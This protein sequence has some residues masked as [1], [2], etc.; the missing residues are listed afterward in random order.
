[1]K[2]A[3]LGLTVFLYAGNTM[4]F[5]MMDVLSAGVSSVAK[6]GGAAIDQALADSPEEV[7]AKL[8]K[9]RAKRD[10]QFK[11]EVAKIEANQ[12]LSPLEKEKMVRQ[13][14]KTFAGVEAAANMQARSEQAK[15]QQ[16]EQTLSMGG[17]AGVVGGAVMNTP[18]MAMARADMAVK[19]GE[20]KAKSQATLA[21]TDALL[22]TGQVQAHNQNVAAQMNG[23]P[24]TGT[25][26][27]SAAQLGAKV[28]SDAIGPVGTALT[29]QQAQGKSPE[30]IQANY[31]Q[32]RATAVAVKDEA[33]KS[34]N[35][36]LAPV[37]TNML[38]QDKGRK[39]YVEFVNGKKYTEQLNLAFK[40]AGIAMV[41]SAQ[42]AE[43][44][45][46]FDGEFYI[47]P[48]P[49]RK[50]VIAQLGYINDTQQTIE[51]PQKEVSTASKFKNLASGLVVFAVA[52]SGHEVP[53]DP[54][55]GSENTY[56]QKVLIVANR[57]FEGKDTRVSELVEDVQP[58][59]VSGKL[60]GDAMSK[61][62]DDVGGPTIALASASPIVLAQIS[63]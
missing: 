19:S 32:M 22:Q 10:A 1:M 36:N 51:L 33:T 46:Q 31:T 9:E 61:L 40:K 2:K 23:T 27:V 53:G 18:S 15:A 17:M 44:I 60:I 7:K 34:V 58:E 25:Q 13:L 48:A 55:A 3:A 24:N 56:T 4:A 63:Q 45:Y 29:P 35:K 47:D 52:A 8:D 43:V 57:H 42:E 30:E 41:G 20:Q 38:A 39:I 12:K 37:V 62:L 59:L 21:Q 26:N 5:G 50:G 6:I 54:N 16:R 14:A 11:E 28:K 49:Q